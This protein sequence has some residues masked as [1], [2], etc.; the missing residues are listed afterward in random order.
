MDDERKIK[1]MPI[2]SW[3]YDISKIMNSVRCG[4]IVVDGQGEVLFGNL[5]Y[6]LLAGFDIRTY[7]G[8]HVREISQNEL[9][10]VPEDMTLF[11]QVKRTRETVS[12]IVQYNTSDQVYTCAIPVLSS[13]GDLDY[14]VYTIINFSETARMRQ[15]L[16]NSVEKNRALENELRR[17]QAYR[18]SAHKIIA[19]TA[20]MRTVFETAARIAPFHAS[21]LITGESGVGKDVLARYIHASSPRA[22][23]NFIAINIGAIPPTLFESELFGY[24]PGAFTGA[25]KKGKLGLIQ[26][27]DKGTLFLDEIGELPLSLQAKLLQVLQNNSVRRVSGETEEPVDVRIITATNQ[28]LEQMVQDGTFRLDLYYRLHVIALH[29]PPLRQRREEINILASRFLYEYNQAFQ[30]EKHFAPRTLEQLRTYAWPGNV[31]ELK[32]TIESMMLTSEGRALTVEDIPIE[33]RQKIIPQPGTM[34]V[35]NNSL[36]L[37]ESVAEFEKQCILAA[38]KQCH[39]NSATADLLGLSTATLIRKRQKYE[40]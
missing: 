2:P 40:I 8:R 14:V 30:M 3:V 13:E 18:L 5:Y 27:S 37:N 26:L 35:T 12:A 1:D 31:R 20:E 24:A 36:C 7:V 17:Q 11:E 15:E 32:H 25:M 28:N 39:T 6:S 19:R 10:V 22:K 29:I 16:R 34:A 33:I 21:V 38:L 23:E 9:V 4:I